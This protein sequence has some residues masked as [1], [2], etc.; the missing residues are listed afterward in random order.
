MHLQLLHAP[1]FAEGAIQLLDAAQCSAFCFGS[2]DGE[3]EPFK[4]VFISFN[5][6]A[7]NYEQTV[8]EAVSR[9][10]SYP[11]ALNEAYIDSRPNLP[12]NRRTT[13]RFFKTE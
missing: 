3:I 11:K 9:G 8:K 4:E 1:I 12:D 6:P 2:E 7:S 13:C 5:K 10:L